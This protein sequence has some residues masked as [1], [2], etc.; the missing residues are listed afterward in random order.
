MAIPGA[1]NATLTLNPVSAGDSGS[2]YQVQVSNT[3]GSVLS[4]VA[5]LNVIP[6]TT[7]PVLVSISTSIS[8]GV[9]RIQLNWS[10]AVDPGAASD[11]FNY[12]FGISMGPRHSNGFSANGYFAHERGIHSGGSVD[13][14]RQLHAANQ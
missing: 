3:A 6:D 12:L 7:P 13:R 14:Q 2:A 4:T 9:L 11:S 1:T 8:A 5:T 10:E